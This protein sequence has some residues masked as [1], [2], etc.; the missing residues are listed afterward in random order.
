MRL[1]QPLFPSPRVENLEPR[2]AAD[3]DRDNATAGFGEE[4]P[5]IGDVTQRAHPR[6]GGVARLITWSVAA[7][8]F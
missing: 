4:W 1:K 2:P 3:T 7:N 6:F 5:N 8:Q